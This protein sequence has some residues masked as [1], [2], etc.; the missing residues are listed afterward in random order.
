MKTTAVLNQFLKRFIRIAFNLI[1][2][3]I[4]SSGGFSQGKQ[5]ND[6][7]ILPERFKS[8]VVANN[9]GQGRHIASNATRKMEAVSRIC[10]RRSRKV[11]G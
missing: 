11:I 7:L 10:S 9:L 6:E 4:V 8:V 5:A 3:L 2:L 1:M